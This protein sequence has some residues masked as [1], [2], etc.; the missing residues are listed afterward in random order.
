M[1][2]LLLLFTLNDMANADTSVSN[3]PTQTQLEAIRRRL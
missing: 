1:A 3:G 2:V